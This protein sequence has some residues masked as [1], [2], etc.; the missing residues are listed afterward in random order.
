MRVVAFLKI[1]RVHFLKT[2]SYAVLC[3]TKTL[4]N[5]ALPFLYKRA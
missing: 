1:I 5:Y 2:D 3:I 4:L